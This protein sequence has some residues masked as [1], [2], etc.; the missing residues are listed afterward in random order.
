[1]ANK[2]AKPTNRPD[3]TR[4]NYQI[5]LS[6]VLVIQ[7]DNNLGVMPTKDALQLAKETGLDLVEVVPHARPPVC[8]IMDFGKFKYEKSMREKKQKTKQSQL[9]EMRLSP[10]IASNDLETK[11]RMVR[12]FLEEG[13]K[14]CLKLKFTGGEMAHQNLG[15]EVINKLIESIQDVG[16]AMQKPK[17]DGRMMMCHVEP[18]KSNSASK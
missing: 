17:I 18:N 15:F 11:T 7:E 3:F 14:V 10:K 5:K 6:P 16:T 9:K 4:I 8:K 1:M 12:K 13:H 2:Y